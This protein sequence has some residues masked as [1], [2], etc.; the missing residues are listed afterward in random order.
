MGIMGST[1]PLTFPGVIFREAIATTVAYVLG[2]TPQVCP[3]LNAN[4]RKEVSLSSVGVTF[5][6]PLL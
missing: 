3:S 1:M 6:Y 5:L 4:P 2:L